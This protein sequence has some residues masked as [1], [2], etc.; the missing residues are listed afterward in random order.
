MNAILQTPFWSVQLLE[1][2]YYLGRSVV[3][4]NGDSVHLSQLTNEQFLD[5]KEV[6]NRFEQAVFTAFGATHFNWTCLMND[7]YKPKNADKKKELHLHVWPRYQHPVTHFGIS[8]VDEVFGHHYD[9]TK[10]NV[11]SPDILK[12]IS[13]AITQV[14]R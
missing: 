5:L 1:N 4:F 6:I 7:Y 2:Q 9:K 10:E 14:W 13:H 12:Q 8:F 3:V 11:V